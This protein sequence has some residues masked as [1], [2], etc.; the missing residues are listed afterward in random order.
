[1]GT[2]SD[3]LTYLN[4]TKTK[5]KDAIN[6]ANTNITNETFRQYESKIKQALINTMNDKWGTWANFEKVT[7]T[8]ETLTLNNTAEAPMEIDLKG[9]TSQYSTTGKNLLRNDLTSQT[10]NDLTITVYDDKTI[11]IN[12]TASANT[13]LNINENFDFE[14]GKTY[15]LSGCASNGSLATYYIYANGQSM[16]DVGSGA[17]KTFSEDVTT[18]IIIKINKNAVL[19]N[20]IF[21]PM[22][23][24]SSIV[25]NTYEPYTN[26]ASPNPNYPQDIHLVSG[27]N[28]IE[29]CG[30][31]LLNISSDNVYI[32][33]I[34]N[35][36]ITSTYNAEK[37]RCDFVVNSLPQRYSQAGYY[38]SFK[39]TIGKIYKVKAKWA[40]TT[41]TPIANTRICSDTTGTTVVNSMTSETEY[42]FTASQ[43]TYYFRVWISN[44]I[45]N[46]YVEYAIVSDS[47]TTYEAFK[48]PQTQLI[49][50]GVEN[51]F[52]KDNPNI[53][54]SK[55]LNS[56]GVETND[57]AFSISDY[58]KVQPNT[59]YTM[60]PFQNKGA[61]L[62]YYDNSKTFISGVSLYTINSTFTTPNNC[63][64]IKTSFGK[65]EASDIQIEKGSK[66]NSYVAYGKTPIELCKIGNYE[67]RPFKADNDDD[68]YKTLDSATKQTLTYG[69]WYLH[70]EIKKA[71]LGTDIS[72]S[73]TTGGYYSASV[74][75]YSISGNTPYCYWYK[76][77]S[78]I[79][80]ISGIDDKQIAFNESSS[81]YPR[82]YL[83]DSDY[84]SATT[85]NSDLSSNNVCIYYVL[86]TPTNTEI[87]DT[88]LI[89]QL[90]NLQN[91][92]SYNP[93]TNIMQ[94]NN[95]KPFILDATLL[96]TV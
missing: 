42:T 52:D 73:S 93:T 14:S 58:I 41:G 89:N 91:L 82:L 48:T 77:K 92:N 63:Y 37:N 59:T 51:L 38:Y 10:I 33:A 26:G 88:T 29:I 20:L 43:E 17:T 5:I 50:L 22:I 53:V 70:K 25:D 55:Y 16:Q 32:N 3:K 19:N 6:L 21:K 85:L 36:D 31:N 94:E 49:S 90:D 81:P 72:F 71:I 13:W 40:N 27:D 78:N 9:N 74:N 83:K 76:G 34:N 87:T 28:T 60:I 46:G 12:G 1:M 95:D 4:T 35:P 61:C 23:R 8:G 62:C 56:S 68:F 57:S 75:D 11:K 44:Q 54:V 15:I 86:A 7:G 96:K 69:K 84:S 65:A 64:Y 30:K 45:G 18:E 79:G 67:D 66:S 80:A 39:T 2:T 47:D 24:L